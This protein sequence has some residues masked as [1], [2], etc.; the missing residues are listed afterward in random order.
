MFSAATSPKIS[1]IS[2][3]ICTR[4]QSVRSNMWDLSMK[5]KWTGHVG[6]LPG[7]PLHRYEKHV[8]IVLLQQSRRRP[9]P[10]LSATLN[11]AACSFYWPTCKDISPKTTTITPLW[12]V[13]SLKWTSVSLDAFNSSDYNRKSEGLKKTAMKLLHR[14]EMAMRRGEKAAQNG[15]PQYISQLDS[16]CRCGEDGQWL[17]TRADA[18]ADPP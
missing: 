1:N 2:A 15:I 5:A 11:T 9:C 17:N 6:I 4:Q 3:Q 12:P 14:L 18:S 10:I 7:V 8:H 13:K 16:C